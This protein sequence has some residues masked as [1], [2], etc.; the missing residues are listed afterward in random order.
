MS[1]DKGKPRISFNNDRHARALRGS[2]EYR[3]AYENRRLIAEV[4]IAVKGMREGAGLTQQQLANAIGSSQ[5]T[6]ARL[7]RGL[8]Q[9]VPRFDLLQRIAWAL[10]KQLKWVFADRAEGMPLVEVARTPRQR[11]AAA[12]NKESRAQEK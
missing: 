3:T 10:N 12:D 5:P 4:A 9:R 8:D 7:E 2:A 11:R 1:D 6:I